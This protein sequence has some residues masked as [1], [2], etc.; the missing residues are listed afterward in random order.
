M[1]TTRQVTLTYAIADNEDMNLNFEQQ[2][3]GDWQCELSE[4]EMNL[5]LK[6]AYDAGKMEP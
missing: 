5:I 3:S 6:T 1:Q 2:E 4:D